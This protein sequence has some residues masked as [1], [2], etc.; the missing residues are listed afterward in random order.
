MTLVGATATGPAQAGCNPERVNIHWENFKSEGVHHH[1][2]GD[3]VRN[4]RQVGKVILRGCFAPVP[5]FIQFAGTEI[6]RNPSQ[7]SFYLLRTFVRQTCNLKLP[8]E[9]P[10]R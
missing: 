3:F 4:A 7:S 1:A 9:S 5:Q 8:F 10:H 6:G 2:F